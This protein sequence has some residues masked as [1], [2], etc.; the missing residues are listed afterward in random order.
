MVQLGMPFE[1]AARCFGWGNL[2]DFANHLPQSSATWRA[3]YEDESRFTTPLQ[4]MATM[5]DIY[6]AISALSYLIA[7]VYGSKGQPPEPYPRPWKKKSDKS[8]GSKPISISE[9]KDWYYGGE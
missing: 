1:D 2:S 8:L 5:A 6:D 9:F 7:K 4:Q 3:L